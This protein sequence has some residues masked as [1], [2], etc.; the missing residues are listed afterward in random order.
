AVLLLLKELATATVTAGTCRNTISWSSKDASAMR[1][2]I[3][4][5]EPGATVFTKIYEQAGTGLQFGAMRNY[6]FVDTALNIAPGTI[7]YR[8]RQVIDTASAGF[9]ADYLDTLTV[10]HTTICNNTVTNP[11]AITAESFQLSPNP[12]SGMFTVKFA[13]PS[14]VANL[15]FQVVNVKGQTVMK[16]KTSAPAGTTSFNF[17]SHGF[18]AGKY[19]VSLYNG[20][21]L[22]GTKELL[23]L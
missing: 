16:Q 21:K 2:E 10:N 14:A 17:S 3:E 13:A 20:E 18:A 8:I 1:Y 7:T 19:F 5:R 12:T 23:K 4:R 11:V 22:I 15:Y 9:T 6:Q